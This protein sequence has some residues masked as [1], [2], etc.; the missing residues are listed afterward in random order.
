MGVEAA[1]AHADVLGEFADG[2]NVESAGGGEVGGGEE[3]GAAG[4]DAV[5]ARFSA[6]GLA[7]G[8]RRGKIL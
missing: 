1:L 6:S 4:F 7:A 3:D 5:G 8:D 2:E